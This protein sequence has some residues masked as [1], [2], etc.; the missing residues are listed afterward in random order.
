MERTSPAD[1]AFRD[2]LCVEI[3]ASKF[4]NKYLCKQKAFE[5]SDRVVMFDPGASGPEQKIRFAEWFRP[6]FAA[7][8]IF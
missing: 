3:N 5:I 4:Y 1:G 7:V 2:S 8:R 6:C